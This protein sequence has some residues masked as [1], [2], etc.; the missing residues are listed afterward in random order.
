MEGKLQLQADAQAGLRLRHGERRTLAARGSAFCAAIGARESRCRGRPA[1]SA[2][3][4]SPPRSMDE[5]IP[6]K[7]RT[8]MLPRTHSHPSRRRS[9]LDSQRPVACRA[10]AS[11]PGLPLA[12]SSATAYPV[13]RGW[14]SARWAR[15]GPGR[16]SETTTSG[17]GD[18]Q[19]HCGRSL[20]TCLGRWRSALRHRGRHGQGRGRRSCRPLRPQLCAVQQNI[21]VRFRRSS[22]RWSSSR[23]GTGGRR[24]AAGMRA[25]P[26]KHGLRR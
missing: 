6:P 21:Q 12:T 8:D 17:E 10:S 7:P 11:I 1:A 25:Q 22:R 4:P 9:G 16:A 19:A 23:Q 3:L 15:L 13:A 14:R 20:G 2:P 5:R 24:R 26:S 18:A